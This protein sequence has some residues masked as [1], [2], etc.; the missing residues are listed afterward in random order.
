MCTNALNHCDG[1]SV[2]RVG[3][4]A[5]VLA[6]LS[7]NNDV[8]GLTLTEEETSLVHV[9][10][11]VGYNVVCSDCLLQQVKVRF[12]NL[13]IA[14]KHPLHIHNMGIVASELWVMLFEG[15]YPVDAKGGII[16]AGVLAED[17]F[18]QVLELPRCD[19]EAKVCMLADVLHQDFLSIWR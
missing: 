14:G 9:V 8:A 7:R 11:V 13:W 4:E 15:C 12:H 18:G 10:D 17:L 5:L 16:V 3:L 6:V 1:L 19:W 2:A